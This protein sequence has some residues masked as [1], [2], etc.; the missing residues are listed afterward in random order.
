MLKRLQCFP[1]FI[2]DSC[3]KSFSL[4]ITFVHKF[5]KSVKTLSKCKVW[6]GL[7]SVHNL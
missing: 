2:S 3:F 7:V 1:T 5:N 6:S 4:I